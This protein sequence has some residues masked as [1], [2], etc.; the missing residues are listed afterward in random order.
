M[1]LAPRS[2]TRS[3]SSSA[4]PFATRESDDR[5]RVDRVRV[6]ER[7][8]L[9][10]PFVQRVD[11]RDRGVGI[12][13]EPLLHHTRQRGPQQRAVDPHVFHQG[14]PR[15]RIEE[16]IEA[17]HHPR[18]LGTLADTRGV[19]RLAMNAVATLGDILA[20]AARYRDPPE[21]GVRDVVADDVV[22]R[23]LRPT[24]DVDV[25]D[26]PV[27]LR[28]QELRERVTV[29]VEVVVGVEGLVRQPPLTH[30]DEGLRHHSPVLRS[31]T[32]STHRISP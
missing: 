16:R 19:T 21:R 6:V 13:R 30:I 23:E 3:S 32:H 5:R 31:P 7:P 26:D 20:V 8:V 24:V 22:D 25:P 10:Q 9:V 12:R 29:L 14:H 28:G 2:A 18:L 17:R 15:F 1:I 11:H 4:G 27:E